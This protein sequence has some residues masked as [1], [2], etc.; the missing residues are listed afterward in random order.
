MRHLDDFPACG[1]GII[2]MKKPQLSLLIKLGSIAVHV[3]EMNDYHFNPALPQY[4]FDLAS[5]TQLLRDSEVT[6]WVKE[7]GA[8]LPV[9]R[10]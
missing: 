5:L 1:H 8:L 2:E 9:K 7:M 4:P 3:D 6:D 10:Q